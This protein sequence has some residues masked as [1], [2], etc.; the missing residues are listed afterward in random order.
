VFE[1]GKTPWIKVGGRRRPDS[2]RSRTPSEGVVRKGVATIIGGARISCELGQE[3]IQKSGPMNM[4]PIKQASG[5]R[6]DKP[7]E[8]KGGPALGR[9]LCFRG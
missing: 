4:P 3:E 8:K 6:K 2:R 7:Q 5:V 1:E 9:K